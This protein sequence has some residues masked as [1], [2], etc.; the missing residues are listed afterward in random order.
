MALPGSGYLPD[1]AG[2]GV[3]NPRAHLE[4]GELGPGDIEEETSRPGGPGKLELPYLLLEA[5]SPHP[6]LD[7]RDRVGQK[8]LAKAE[9]E[10]Y[11]CPW[12]APLGCPM[13]RDMPALDKCWALSP[14]GG[15]GARMCGD[16]VWGLKQGRAGP[17][18]RRGLSGRQ[19]QG[20]CGVGEAA[21]LR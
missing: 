1:S 12:E 3:S 2:M 8:R 6:F 11:W 20:A 7:S 10:P 15:A 21:H 4:D 18:W 5:P 17:A 14:R 9:A 16:W 19:G 13:V